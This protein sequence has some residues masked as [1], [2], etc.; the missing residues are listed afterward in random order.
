ML[1]ITTN[2]EINLTFK[3]PEFSVNKVIK[4]NLNVDEQT[5]AGVCLRFS[6]AAI[7]VGNLFSYIILL[8]APES[9]KTFNLLL[10]RNL[11]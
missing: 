2:I 7:V 6:V 10:F 8:E 11:F 3:L 9:N 4:W 1:S 5:H